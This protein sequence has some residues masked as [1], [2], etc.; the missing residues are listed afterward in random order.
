MVS[1]DDDNPYPDGTPILVRFPRSQAEQQA[2]R[3]AWPYLPGMIEQRC[4][5]DEWQVVVTDRQVAEAEDGTPAPDG[6]PAEDLYWPLCY[7]DRSEIKLRPASLSGVTEPRR[8]AS[9]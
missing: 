9:A 2:D 4:G 6:T 3:D 7:R 5:P 1:T 8:P